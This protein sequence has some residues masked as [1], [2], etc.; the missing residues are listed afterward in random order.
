MASVCLCNGHLAGLGTRRERSDFS[1]PR[2]LSALTNAGYIE[3]EEVNP[4][5]KK[6]FTLIAACCVLAVP[7]AAVGST[8]TQAASASCK[9]QLKASGATNFAVLY[10][11]L[12]ACVSHN[13]KL[14]AQKRQ[15]LLSAEKQ[16][17]TEQ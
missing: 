11:S 14:T 1:L 10:T 9:S 3:T 4:S 13:A 16:C 17:R 7:A 8:P 2:P 12:G 15:S 6:V 5:M